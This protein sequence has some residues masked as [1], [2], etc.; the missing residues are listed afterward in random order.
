MDTDCVVCEEVCPVS[1]K[2]I[3][4]RNV[5][6]TDRWGAKLELKRPYIDPERC[7]GCGIC[8]HECPVKDDPARLRHRHRRDPRQ[9]PLAAPLA[10]RGRRAGPG[11][12]LSAG[13]EISPISPGL[14]SNGDRRPGVFVRRVLSSTSPLGTDHVSRHLVEDARRRALPLPPSLRGRGPHRALPAAGRLP[15][16]RVAGCWLVPLRIALL[17]PGGRRARAG[18]ERLLRTERR[19]SMFGLGA[20]ALRSVGRLVRRLAAWRRPGSRSRPSGVY[21]PWLDG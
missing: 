20:T 10:R 3:F 8:E 4:T 19:R 6:V 2:A 17:S 21:D 9:V 5:E 16:A 1:P 15:L 7:I 14:R 11:L 12:G 13:R 18:I